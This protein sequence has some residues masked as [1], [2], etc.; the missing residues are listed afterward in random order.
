MCIIV[1]DIADVSGTNIAVVVKPDNRQLVVYSNRVI[2]A[3]DREWDSE[4]EAAAAAAAKPVAMIL[5]FPN[6]TGRGVQVVPTRPDDCKVFDMLDEACTPLPEITLGDGRFGTPIA[7]SDSD[8]EV[9]RSGSYRYSIA[10]TPADLRRADPTV[11][12][13]LPADLNALIAQY[14]DAMF[15]FLV[16]IIDASA[17]YSPFAYLCDRLPGGS[18]GGGGPV[19]VPTKHYHT[20]RRH[21]ATATAATAAAAAAAAADWDHNVYLLGVRPRFCASIN[22]SGKGA[23]CGIDCLPRG[24]LMASAL[25]KEIGKCD[26]NLIAY[27]RLHGGGGGG[28]GDA[29][30]NEDMVMEVF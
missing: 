19:F 12:T 11:F 30:P 3:A 7:D 18:G 24:P 25:A 27:F 8:L 14:A 13:D 4:V 16:C 1:G 26:A 20:R 15:G 22:R 9:F 28:G 21:E 23:R 6:H 5:P 29:V 10:E 2:L 17:A